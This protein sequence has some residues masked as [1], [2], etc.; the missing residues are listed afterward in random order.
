VSQKASDPFVS[1]VDRQY[2]SNIVYNITLEAPVVPDWGYY[3]ISSIIA[4]QLNLQCKPP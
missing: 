4:M 2:N 1:C 3:V